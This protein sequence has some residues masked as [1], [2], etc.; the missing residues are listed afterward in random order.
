MLQNLVANC[1][2]NPIAGTLWREKHMCYMN[3]A[4]AFNSKISDMYSA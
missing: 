1:T 3:A 4:F 2:K